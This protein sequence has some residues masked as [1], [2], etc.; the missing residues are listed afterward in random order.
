MKKYIAASALSLA[1]SYTY[2]QSSVT[3]YGLVS[4]SV[5]Y[6]SNEGGHSFVG[7][8]QN[9]IQGS[10]FGLTG[11]EDLGGGLAAIFTLEN[12]FG[13]LNGALSGGSSL[14]NR[15]AVV[16]LSGKNLGTVT[17]GRQYDT[18]RDFL[19]QYV[20]GTEYGAISAFIGDNDNSF[21]AFRINNSIKYT[22]PNYRGFQAGFLYGASNSAGNFADNRSYSIGA[23]W[24][25]GNISVGAGYLHMNRPGAA[26]NTSGSVT[27]DYGGLFRSSALNPSEGVD[28][29]ENFGLGGSYT[30]GRLALSALISRSNFTYLDATS[31]HLNNYQANAVYTLTPFLVLGLGYAFTNG[32][33]GATNAK[34]KWHQ[35]TFGL[36]YLLS[37]RTDLELVAI[38]QR[39]AGDAT[40]ANIFAVPASSS[41]SQFYIS[42]GIRLK[43]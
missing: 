23:G 11:R 27:F 36:D 5:A 32:S 35:G 18:L 16:G 10:R 34:P 30:L 28:V 15:I 14:F 43:F 4:A 24:A 26:T 37:K 41:K 33:Y 8:R 31:L 6:V 40:V 19:T 12:G 13:P 22:T 20:A 3:L 42:A 7:L 39:A 2:A 25:G 17:I 1:A 9:D 38:Y 29:Q 21:G